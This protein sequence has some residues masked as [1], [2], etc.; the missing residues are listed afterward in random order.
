MRQIVINLLIFALLLFSCSEES[1]VPNYNSLIEISSKE[2]FKP[3]E[4]NP[5][6]EVGPPGVFDAGALGSMTILKVEDTF[7][8][9]YEAWKVRSEKEWDAIEYETLSIGH[10][11]SKDGVHWVK[12]PANPVLPKGESGEWDET[13]VWDPY[14]IYEDGLFKMWYGGGGGSKPNYGWAYAVSEDGS[15]FEKKGLI[16]K[17][18]PTAAEDVHVVHDKESNQ[19]YLYYWHGIDEP[20]ALRLVKSTTETDFN[21]NKR[22]KVVIEGDNSFMKKFGQV[23]KDK[24]GWHLFYSNCVQPYCPNSIVRYARSNDGIHFKTINK[25]VLNG[26]D[27]DVLRVTDDLYMMVYSPQK[28]FDAKGTDIRLAVYNG[29]LPGLA[30]EWPESEEGPLSLQGKE[31]TIDVGWNELITFEFR[32]DGEVVYWPAGEK[33][34]AFNALYIQDGNNIAIK[35]EGLHLKGT[36]DGESLKLVSLSEEY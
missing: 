22:I 25:K 6:L 9:Y 32:E 2:S 13:G 12:D 24:D 28:G 17:N 14:V 20:D 7:H 3:Y 35:G 5:I 27:A 30:R 31:F 15:H 18:N 4:D 23:I 8:I 26:H 10:A 19:Y 29:R 1:S 33:F 36:Y 34:D 11:T 21:F 16:G